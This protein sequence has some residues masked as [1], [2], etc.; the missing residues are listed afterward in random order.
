MSF[1]LSQVKSETTNLNERGLNPGVL[2]RRL[3]LSVLEGHV[4]ERDLVVTSELLALLEGEASVERA[5][6]HELLKLDLSLDLPPRAEVEGGV[7]AIKDGIDL[8]VEVVI[9]GLADHLGV[10]EAPAAGKKKRASAIR[11]MKSLEGEH[12]AK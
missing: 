1:W 7:A 6:L 9:G 8:R 10:L 2:R 3:R 5:V 12:A 11:N 4:A